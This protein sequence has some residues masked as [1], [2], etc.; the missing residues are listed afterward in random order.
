MAN[1]ELLKALLDTPADQLKEESIKM[2]Q[3]VNQLSK[4]KKLEKLAGEED[5]TTSSQLS[6]QL[7]QSLTAKREKP[8]IDFS[9]LYG[10]ASPQVAQALMA[11][12]GKKSAFSEDEER[13]MKALEI[14]LG[15]EKAQ[16]DEIGD[17]QAKRLDL[18]EQR[19]QLTKE[20]QANLQEQRAW[21][22]EQKDEVSDKQLETVTGFQNVSERLQEIA[23]MKKRINTGPYATMAQGLKRYTTGEDP[24]FA[25]FSAMSGQNLFDYVKNQSGVQYSA[26]ELDNLKRNMPTIEDNDEAFVSKLSAVVDIVQKKQKRFLTNVEKYQGKKVYFDANDK[27]IVKEEKIDAAPHGKRIKQGDKVY[28]WN[29]SEYIE[30]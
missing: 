1:E 2:E 25:A 12:Q 26:K 13:T 18:M 10:L 22:R 27:P 28:I 29:G 30:E 24:D 9:A 8:G 14:A 3:V 6:Q 5:T 15:M 19:L 20:R 11:S 16:K 23:E 4:L 7:L 21:S 17:Y